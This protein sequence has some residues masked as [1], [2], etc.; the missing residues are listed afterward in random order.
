[1][2]DDE[3]GQQVGQNVRIALTIAMQMGEKFARLRAEMARDAQA[4]E[5]S[6]RFDAERSAA[7]ASGV[8][9]GLHA[10]PLVGALDMVVKKAS[11]SSVHIRPV[12]ASQS[13]HDLTRRKLPQLSVSKRRSICGLL[14]H[15][16]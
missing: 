10:E 14:H 12:V 8:I 11:I 4:R 5:L 16:V 2:S 7:R 15:H 1:M 13:I 3:V 6:A 9:G